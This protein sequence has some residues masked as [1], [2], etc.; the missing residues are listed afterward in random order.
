VTREV[1][2]VVVLVGQVEEN[3]LVTPCSGR[4]LVEL[5][6]GSEFYVGVDGGDRKRRG[7]VAWSH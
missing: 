5:G 7:S 6:R 4:A 2:G 1:V 3:W